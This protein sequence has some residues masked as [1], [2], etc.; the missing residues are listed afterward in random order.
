MQHDIFREQLPDSFNFGCCFSFPI[1]ALLTKLCQARKPGFSL[2]S[3]MTAEGGLSLWYTKSQYEINSVFLLKT[4]GLC[5]HFH[6]ICKIMLWE[7]E[8][9]WRESD[10]ERQT[11]KN[12]GW[13]FQFNFSGYYFVL[14]FGLYLEVAKA[15]EK[16]VGANE[17]R[18]LG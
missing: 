9:I 14:H 17:T 11:E 7:N 3:Y 6:G 16:S 18:W 2:C 13:Q 1:I 4:M 8:Y 12:V 5:V 10:R 15:V